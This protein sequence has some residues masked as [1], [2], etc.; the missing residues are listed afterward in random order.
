MHEYNLDAKFYPFYARLKPYNKKLYVFLYEAILNSKTNIIIPDKYEMEDVSA[1]L[2]LVRKDHPELFWIGASTGYIIGKD[3][4]VKNINL[5]YCF[6]KNE[7]PNKQNEF[8][9]A[10][11]YFTS[12][13]AGKSDFEKEKVIHDRLVLNL[14]YDSNSHD[15]T[16]YGS[17]VNKK[18]VCAGYARGF[19]ILMRVVGIPCFYVSGKA[20]NGKNDSWERHAWNMV[21]LN[22]QYYNVDV[23]WNNRVRGNKGATHY[24]YNCNDEDF[25]KGHVRDEYGNILPDCIDNNYTFEQMYGISPNVDEVLQD[26]V[27]HKLIIDNKEQFIKVFSEQYI[28][29]KTDDIITIA[30]IVNKSSMSKKCMNWMKSYLVAQKWHGFMIRSRIQDFG[31]S[32]YKLVIGVKFD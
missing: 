4:I 16:A 25:S 22:G 15:Q 9:Q 28:K 19:Q 3:R 12:G 21:C 24:Y 31:N 7:L 5:D 13:L 29:S 23:T 8:K 18:A 6:N 30:F 17:L 11:I 27:T 32:T 14:E 2:N 26:G 20:R 1:I 10:I